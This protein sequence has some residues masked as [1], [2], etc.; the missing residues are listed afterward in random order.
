M[1]KFTL[2]LSV[3]SNVV[4]LCFI[5][6]SLLENSNM[7]FMVVTDFRYVFA[8]IITFTSN[9]M[10]HVTFH[11]RRPNEKNRGLGLSS[12]TKNSISIDESKKDRNNHL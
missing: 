2:N 1:S 11:R 10:L 4:N 6:D 5:P 3:D 12:D 8:Y 9:S 7:V